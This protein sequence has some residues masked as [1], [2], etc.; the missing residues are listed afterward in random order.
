MGPSRCWGAAVSTD[1]VPAL[2]ASQGGI[3]ESFLEAHTRSLARIFH[4]YQGSETVVEE[5]G[6]QADFMDCC[7]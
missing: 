3:S 7:G 2:T 6:L 1:V 4:S 5:P